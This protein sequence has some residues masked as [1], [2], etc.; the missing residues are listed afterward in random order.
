MK[1]ILWIC[2]TLFSAIL[3]IFLFLWFGFGLNSYSRARYKI[4]LLPDD[5]K[6]KVLADFEGK[7][8]PLLYSGILAGINT[9]RYIQGVW[10][11]GRNGLKFFRTDSLPVYSY[12]NIC[13]DQTIKAIDNA[14]PISIDR[15]IDTDLKAWS[16]KVKTGQFVTIVVAKPQKGKLLSSLREAK[17]HDWWAFMPNVDIKKLCEK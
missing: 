8:D 15:V 16:K 6:A 3:I 12:F 9:S 11:W 17:G 10:V 5:K 2:A 1:K 13:S 4:F 7:D 14:G